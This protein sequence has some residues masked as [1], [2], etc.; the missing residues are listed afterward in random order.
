M[1]LSDTQSAVLSRILSVMRE[2]FDDPEL[3]LTPETTDRH[4]DGW[5]SLAHIQLVSALEAEFELDISAA[6]IASMNSVTKILAL[7]AEKGKSD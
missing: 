1:P 5:D 2:I 3:T 7:I 6:E 4:I